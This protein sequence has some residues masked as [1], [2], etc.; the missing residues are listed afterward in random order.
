MLSASKSGRFEQKKSESS[1]RLKR[2]HRLRLSRRH[3]SRRSRTHSMD[4]FASQFYPNLRKGG[5]IIDV[6]RNHGGNIDT[7]VLERLRR[8]AWMFESHRSGP[9]ETTMQY[10]FRGKV[11][12]LIDEMSSSDAELFAAGFQTMKLGKVI[13]ARSWGGAVGYSGNPECSLVDG[14][15]FHY[16]IVWS[17][18]R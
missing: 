1:S 2:H 17:I 7:W 15:S 18:S 4:D 6:R 5:L 9:G 8:V 14:G 13:G 10:S 16:P 11:V 12:V 3:G